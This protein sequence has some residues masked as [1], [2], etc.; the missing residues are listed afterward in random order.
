[1]CRIAIPRSARRLDASL[2]P[3]TSI[4][5]AISTAGAVSPPAE[6]VAMDD[7]AEASCAVLRSPTLR[8]TDGSAESGH[9]LFARALAWADRVITR[10][11]E[12]RV[13]VLLSTRTHME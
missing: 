8:T 9:S 1:M 11:N 12:K 13:R 6:A 7:R 3:A 2:Q 4:K 5:S 10:S